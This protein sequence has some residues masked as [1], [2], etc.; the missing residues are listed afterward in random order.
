P[1]QVRSPRAVAMAAHDLLGADANA[2]YPQL[3][4][5]R[6]QF[7][8]VARFADPAKA[9]LLAKRNLAG[10][11]FYQEERRAYPQNSVASQVIGYAGVDNHGLEGLEIAYDRPLSGRPGKQTTVRDP[12]GRAIAGVSTAPE[13]EGED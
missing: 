7:V 12:F 2:L 10:V 5:K 9:A 11:G 6:K 8:Y 1:R 13:P 3:L 4:D